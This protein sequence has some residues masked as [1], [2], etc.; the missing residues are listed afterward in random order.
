MQQTMDA[1]AYRREKQIAYNT[2]NNITPK[3]IKK[4]LDNALTKEKQE[5][6]TATLIE[7]LAAESENEYLSLSQLEKKIRDTRKAMEKAAKE[8]D[9]LAAAKL[10]DTIKYYQK[11]LEL[12]KKS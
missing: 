7:N 11:E 12:L 6:Y 1:T 4:S 9:F 3:A 8:L 2:K 10:R 5:I